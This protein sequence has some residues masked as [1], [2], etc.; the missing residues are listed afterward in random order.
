MRLGRNGVRLITIAWIVMASVSGGGAAHAA[1][2]VERVAGG[3][4]EQWWPS[5][6]GDFVAYSQYLRGNHVMLLDAAT[7]EA[8]PIDP[9]AASTYMG[10]FIAGT[11][12]LVYQRG[13]ADSHLYFYDVGSSVHSRVPARVYRDGSQS[14]PVGSRDHLLYLRFT[15][16]RDLV[17][18]LV[19]FDRSTGHKRVLVGDIG[20]HRYIFP[21]FV[22]EDFAA[23]TDCSAGDC[24]VRIYDIGAGTQ[25]SVP[26]DGSAQYAPT[27]DEGAG[28][29][30]FVR[31]A[32]GVC[33]SDVQIRRASLTSLGMSQGVAALHSGV[34]TDFSMAL[35]P[36]PVSGKQ[37][38]FFTRV[39]CDGETRDVYAVRS[40]AP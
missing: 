14:L 36:N 8:R 30:Y 19:L 22:G 34:D 17:E 31:S 3:A 25:R 21:G 35:A 23:W 13:G 39:R 32:Q 5:S 37:D 12:R 28:Q 4:G 27:L 7:G 26:D 16:D 2:L 24:H 11:D 15:G 6:D 20:G 1:A 9:G 40:I 33:G 38:L 18:D 29:L 10:S